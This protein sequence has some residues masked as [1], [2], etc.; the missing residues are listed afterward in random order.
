M[1]VRFRREHLISHHK[2]SAIAKGFHTGFVD[3]QT[4]FQFVFSTL[5]SR[6]GQHWEVLIETYISAFA[7]V[8]RKFLFFHV[9]LHIHFFAFV[10][11]ETEAD[12]IRMLIFDSQFYFVCT[13]IAGNHVFD[14]TCSV[15]FER[16]FLGDVTQFQQFG[17]GSRLKISLAI[18]GE[19]AQIARNRVRATVLRGRNIVCILPV[20]HPCD[21]NATV[22]GSITPSNSGV[23]VFSPVH[24]FGFG[25]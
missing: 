4:E 19:Q 21:S 6:P 9:I 17:R 11:V 2:T 24:P 7:A 8:H 3:Q 1:S 10:I 15:H 14:D 22:V 5:N 16:A 20:A 18:Y 23:M 13:L 12:Y 25:G